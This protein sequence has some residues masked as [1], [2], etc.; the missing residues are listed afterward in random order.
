MNQTHCDQYCSMFP[1]FL[2]Y[3]L[4][5]WISCET[6]ISRHNQYL[7]DLLYT[8]HHSRNIKYLWFRSSTQTL[9]TCVYFSSGLSGRASLIP[10]RKCGSNQKS[11]F[12]VTKW[13]VNIYVCTWETQKTEGISSSCLRLLWEIN[14]IKLF[15]NLTHL[16]YNF[17]PIHA[18]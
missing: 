5:Y 4:I 7:D 10:H 1:N 18:I 17:C 9:D 12:E 11:D 8:L 16:W 13:N 2:D 14:W 3:Q 15:S 6:G